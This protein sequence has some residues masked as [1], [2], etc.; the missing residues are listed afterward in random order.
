MIVVATENSYMLSYIVTS[1]VRAVIVKLDRRIVLVSM[2]K[3]RVE[4]G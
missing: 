3:Y 1:E 2:L 4:I